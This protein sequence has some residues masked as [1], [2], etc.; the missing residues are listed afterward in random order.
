M[1]RLGAT[2]LGTRTTGM[3]DKGKYKMSG[4]PLAAGILTDNGASGLH[5]I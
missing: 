3:G 4:S 2:A 1:P 5:G